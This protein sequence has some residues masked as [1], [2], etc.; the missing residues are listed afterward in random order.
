MAFLKK[1][2]ACSSL[3]TD[4]FVVESRVHFPTDYNLLWDSL[5]KCLDTV[6][7]IKQKHPC[8]TGWRKLKSWKRTFKNCSRRIGQI[9]GL[10]GKNKEENLQKEVLFYTEKATEFLVKLA[11]SI[12]DF[13]MDDNPDMVNLIDLET[14]TGFALK[15]ND[16]LERRILKAR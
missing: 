11:V 7:K 6:E 14:Y 1:E 13:P 16:L 2:M 10:G 8:I 9:S 3:K 15:L 12:P 4:S 5:R